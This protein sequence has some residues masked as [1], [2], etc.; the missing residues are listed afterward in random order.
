M[1]AAPAGRRAA[2]TAQVAGT[3]ARSGPPP[4]T[5]ARLARARLPWAPRSAHAAHDARMEALLAAAASASDPARRRIH[6]RVTAEYLSL[7][8]A[9]ANRFRTV[10]DDI[11]DV[12]Q[13]A[14]LGLA[15]AV[16]RFDP[17]QGSGFAAFAVPTISGEIKRHLRD[18]SWSVRPPRALQELTGELSDCASRL[19]QQLGREP[20]LAELA[21]AVKRPRRIVAAAARCQLARTALS[22]DSTAH[23][24]EDSSSEPLGAL[25]PY[26]PA[27]EPRADALLV[28][29][30]AMQALTADER[31]IV[32]LRFAEDLTQAQIASDLGVSQMQVSRLLSRILAVLRERLLAVGVRGSAAFEE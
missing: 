4:G 21:C 1:S 15:K 6:Q 11:D 29:M 16:R 18:Y 25:R 27:F 17:G 7:A 12:R 2:T 8:D 13:A 19:A 24:G 32:R 20:T 3:P 14:Y 5:S 26:E 22:L 23:D 28:L 31:R 30:D 10:A 9:V